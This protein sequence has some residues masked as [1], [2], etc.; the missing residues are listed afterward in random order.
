M[1][2]HFA[3]LLRALDVF[4]ED[5]VTKVHDSAPL[6]PKF[7]DVLKGMRDSFA[8]FLR[9][10]ED[11]E[12]TEM[13]L[14]LVT[15]S[16]GLEGVET[17]QC[18]EQE[19]EKEQE[20]EQEQEIEMERYV[21]LAYLRDGEEMKNWAF[22]TLGGGCETPQFYPADSFKLYGRNPLP[23]SE[24]L[25]ISV[26]HYD[27]KWVGDRRLKNACVVLELIPELAKLCP[28]IPKATIL[29]DASNAR[30]QKALKLMDVDNSGSFEIPE[31]IEVLKSAE[32]IDLTEAELD[33]LLLDS[34]KGLTRSNSG[35]LITDPALDMSMAVVKRRTT[36]S[37]EELQ[38]VL[39]MGKYRQQE[40]GRRFVLL[41]LA[42]AETIRCILHLRQG[43]APVEGC[44]AAMAL[45]CV[46]ANDIVLDASSNFVSSSRYQQSVAHNSFRF[47]NSDTHYKPGDINI[48]LREIP[49]E[50]LQRRF[51]FTAMVACRRCVCVCVCVCVCNC[52]ACAYGCVCVC[53]CGYTHS[54]YV[55][56]LHTLCVCVCV[57]VCVYVSYVC[58]CVI[59]NHT[60][61]QA[62]GQAVG[63]DAAR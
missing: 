46:C 8:E 35:K 41:S 61:T 19:Q 24:D 6:R 51:F 23:F 57:C 31:L 55:C 52:A 63:A 10:S 33:E 54:M 59:H 18:R 30:L 29:S 7:I 53:V 45:R 21:D 56:V 17:E 5:V 32:D 26:N 12:V 47:F 42:E 48:L 37:F 15:N 14:G 22:C 40:A 25:H 38:T 39:T 60:H 43:K 9:K 1:Q 20:Q 58:V 50:P 3:A 44:D 34:S 27:P 16:V 62:A 11:I 13:I 4:M 49:A 36:L 2:E 28:K